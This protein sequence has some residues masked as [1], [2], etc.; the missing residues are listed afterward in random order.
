LF[1]ELYRF[2]TGAG[3]E[4]AHEARQAGFG[5]FWRKMNAGDAGGRQHAREAFFG[6]RGFERRAV[7][8]ELVTGN[9]E[10]HA[11]FIFGAGAESG[12]KF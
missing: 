11:G 4:T 10:E 1:G 3:G 12:A 5:D 6:S 9:G 7:E 2:G 8:E